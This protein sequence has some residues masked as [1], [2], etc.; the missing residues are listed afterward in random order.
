MLSR[1]VTSL[2]QIGSPLSDPRAQLHLSQNCPTLAD[3]AI[4]LPLQ[5]CDENVL[6]ILRF[7]EGECEVLPSKDRC[8][9]LLVCEVLERSYPC[10]SDRLYAQAALPQ[11]PGLLENSSSQNFNQDS[12][13][14]NQKVSSISGTYDDQLST[15]SSP[16]SSSHMTDYDTESSDIIQTSLMPENVQLFARGPTIVSDVSNISASSD[17]S[18]TYPSMS[19]IQNTDRKNSSSPP[20]GRTEDTMSTTLGVAQKKR[21]VDWRRR[22]L[23]PHELRGGD[24][25][26]YEENFPYDRSDDNDINPFLRPQSEPQPIYSSLDSG[27]EINTPYVAQPA[28]YSNDGQYSTES[29]ITPQS[30]QPSYFS[31]SPPSP[32]SPSGYMSINNAALSRASTLAGTFIRSKTAEEKRELVRSTSVFGHLPGWKLKSFIVKSGDDLRK[33]VL[34]MQLIEHC[35]QIFQAEGLDISLRPYQIICT[36]PQTGLI[37]FLEGTKS[38]DRIKKSF[39]SN[40]DEYSSLDIGTIGVSS[41]TII[42]SLRDYFEFCFGPAYTISHSQAVQ[43]FV[44]S[45]IGY[46][47]VTYVLQVRVIN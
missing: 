16:I 8:P 36:G 15:S 26:D 43:N 37:E 24:S 30:D 39:R 1:G 2:Q 44:R 23:Q 3:Y 38:I 20:S 42:P 10:K 45:L 11:D 33:E 17:S 46:S 4:H 25:N 40:S 14:I 19:S 32:Q 27:R 35:Q 31:S 29:Y 41:G 5:H 9:Y 47:L 22:R 28:A 13:P 18:T 7:V 12:I 21:T 34:A 6:R